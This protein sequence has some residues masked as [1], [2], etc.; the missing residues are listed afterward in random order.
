MGSKSLLQIFNRKKALIDKLA[1]TPWHSLAESLPHALLVVDRK[2]DVLYSNSQAIAL[3]ENSNL[4]GLPILNV[5]LSH[6]IDKLV[7]DCIQTRI[8]DSAE[9]SL[10]GRS[11]L[12]TQVRVWPDPKE[13]NWIY[14]L[15]EDI[16]EL[17]R[18]ETVR[19]DFVA[20][21]SHELRTPL[22]NIR[23]MA[24][25][26]ADCGLEDQAIFDR[27][28]SQIVSEVDRLSN[29]VGDLLTL[30]LAESLLPVTELIDLVPICYDVIEQNTPNAE[31]KGL[32]I[33]SSLPN[34]LCI[35]ANPTQI[36]QVLI[37]LLDNAVN[38]TNKGSVKLTLEE[39]EGFA[40]IKISDSGIGISS[41][42]LNRVFER[43][44]RVDKGRSR[45]SGGTGLGLSIVKHI[46]EQHGGTISALSMLN[47][48]SEFTVRLPKISP[49]G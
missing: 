25:T 38:Y 32:E 47:R 35:N 31:E 9:Y 3:F 46:V 21:V 43:F 19:T 14:V 8:I 36:T 20:N 37:N 15:I 24:E 42:H 4:V 29:I 41:E 7:R 48:G 40:E 23:A 6:G 30:G 45:I 10:R 16:S 1:A 2:A 22:T 39:V 33:T 49:L 28:Q 11:D 34:S 5:T 18:L 44:Y 27:F 17:R 13:P 12:I 26:L